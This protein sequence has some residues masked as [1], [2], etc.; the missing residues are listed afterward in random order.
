MH[1]KTR[2]AFLIPGDLSLPTGGYTYDRRVLP[3]L[4]AEDLDV[5]HIELP[6]A[7]PD[8]SSAD[9]AQTADIVCALPPGIVLLI[10]GL[11][12][13]AMPE[14][15]IREFDRPIVALCHHPLA[16]EE[17]LS[18]SRRAELQAS[19]TT[20][21]ALS[22]AV[23]VTSPSIRRLLVRDFGVSVDR[24][25]VAVPGTDPAPRSHGT[26]DPLQLLA[27]GSIVP[28]KGYDWLIKALARLTD[29]NWHLTIAGA[30]DRSPETAVELRALVRATGLNDRVTFMGAVLGERLSQLYSAA[31]V[32]VMS[33]LFEGYGMVLAEAM[34]NGLPIVC[35]TGGAAAETAPD[36]AAL[37]VAPADD[38]VLADAI[39]TMISRLDI[40]AAMADA[41]WRAGLALPRWE[42]TAR[43]IAGVIRNAAIRKAKA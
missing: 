12:Y 2:A 17:G 20:A 11:A 29:C 30:L 8:P 31:D 27:V 24:I 38:A 39:R 1:G 19:E 21:L 26:N 18:P 23:I 13:G 5:T 37:K 33:S 34:A 9:L 40:R 7:Y 4:A 43:I 15:L 42:D 16:L 28:R 32:F 6:A 25:A 41:S 10:D 22:Q 35:T 3:L 14:H 36:E